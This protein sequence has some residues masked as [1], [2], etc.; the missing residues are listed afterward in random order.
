MSRLRSRMRFLAAVAALRTFIPISWAEWWAIHTSIRQWQGH[1]IKN[2]VSDRRQPSWPNCS[3]AIQGILPEPVIRVPADR[4]LVTVRW[5]VNLS[6]V[7]NPA[8]V[9]WAILGQYTE[10]FSLRF[11]VPLPLIAGQMNS[12]TGCPR[13]PF[14]FWFVLLH[15]IFYF[16]IYSVPPTYVHKHTHIHTHTHPLS[17]RA[18][19]SSC[20]LPP[21]CVYMWIVDFRHGPSGHRRASPNFECRSVAA[22]A[23]LLLPSR[24]YRFCRRPETGLRRRPPPPHHPVSEA[25]A[26]HRMR[27]V[28]TTPARWRLP[29]RETGGPSVRWPVPAGRTNLPLLRMQRSVSRHPPPPWSIRLSL[30]L[31]IPGIRHVI[32]PFLLLFFHFLSFPFWGSFSL[33]GHS[34]LDWESLRNW[35]GCVSVC[36]SSRICYRNVIRS[37]SA[38]IKFARRESVHGDTDWIGLSMIYLLFLL[39]CFFCL[40][41]I[42]PYRIHV[43]TGIRATVR[44]S[45]TRDRWNGRK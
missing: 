33:G 32:P 4:H 41:W 9:S 19:V 44:D 43:V 10:F 36:V 18:R 14:A 40:D 39:F 37:V 17:I 11:L 34:W 8:R 31:D 21:L 15:V 22:L 1:L 29:D 23:N 35:S 25:M 5:P 30:V 3:P 7:G 13:L 2:L 45:V 16:I 24:L 6:I 27:W 12:W 38:F 28:T 42:S 20:I 26:D